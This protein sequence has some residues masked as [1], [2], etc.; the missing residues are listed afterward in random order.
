M[1]ELSPLMNHTQPIIT[2]FDASKYKAFAEKRLSIVDKDKQNVPFVLHPSQDSLLGY[3]Q[4]YLLILV[5]KARKMGFSSLALAVAVAKFIYGQ[6]E[7]CVTM[8]FDAGAAEQQLAR[9]KHFIESYELKTQQKIP[10]KYNSKTVMSWSGIDDNGAPFT[11]VLRTGTAR[12]TS[13]GRGDDITYLHL[14]EVAFCDDVPTLLAGVGE[15]VVH[16]AHI[17]LETTANGFNS[18]KDFWDRSMTDQTGF[19]A[20]FYGPEWEYDDAYLADRA[21]KLGKLFAQEY[22]RTPEE[23]FIASGDTYIDKSALAQLLDDVMD[24]ERRYGPIPVS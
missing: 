2:N 14:T 4:L 7:R 1:P 21:L 22:P 17:I 20:L 19:A 18:Y 23:A 6:N 10:Y 15:A 8:S 24:F 3:M 16:G 5:L 11:N 12:S 9:A 13:F